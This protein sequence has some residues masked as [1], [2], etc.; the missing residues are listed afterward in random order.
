L[1]GD[2]DMPIP[3]TDSQTDGTTE[4]TQTLDV[5][6]DQPEVSDGATQEETQ[7]SSGFDE[8]FLKGL[9]SLDPSKI[10]PTTL[11][12]E[13]NDRFVSKAEFTRKSQAV[14]DEKRLLAE[15]EKAVFDLARKVM[16]DREKPSG[17]SPVDI[18]K[19][20]L[21]ALASA[22]DG[23]ALSQ[24]IKMEAQSL[25]EP[26][27][28]QQT[29]RRAAETARAADPSV[30]QHWDEIVRTIDSDPALNELASYGNHKYAD[31]VMLAL[32]LEHKAKDLAASLAQRDSELA[33]LKQKLSLY[34]KD[35]ISG[36]PP[37]TT[38]A[39]ITS[40]RP[41]VGEAD[42]IHDAAYAAWIESGGRR[43]DFR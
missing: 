43:E 5:S 23:E 37:S 31:K 34:E 17:P 25:V 36:L 22:G 12:K 8:N 7:A 42:N 6:N 19:Q 39:G 35:R 3:G 18:K 30:V 15:R 33:T 21:I 9:A 26:V 29:I 4:E 10:D 11:P 24:L 20:E 28:T 41:A 2:F 27:Q 40:G 16:A 1:K 32:G 38:K 13:F 14:A